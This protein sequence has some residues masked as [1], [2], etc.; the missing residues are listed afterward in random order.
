MFALQ[1]LVL[2]FVPTEAQCSFTRLLL[3]YFRTPALRYSRMIST[4]DEVLHQI[5][6][7]D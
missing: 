1:L 3:R 7:V 5:S 6:Q 4:S 2:S